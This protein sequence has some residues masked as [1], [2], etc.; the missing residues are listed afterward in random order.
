MFK[1]ILLFIFA[2]LI[3]SSNSYSI[4]VSQIEAERR[5]EFN[6]L[7]SKKTCDT[8]YKNSSFGMKKKLEN[9]VMVVTYHNI[10]R[11]NINETQSILSL[12][13]DQRTFFYQEPK[14]EFII[15]NALSEQD[16]SEE[17]A[18]INKSI[19]QAKTK[20][21]VVCEFDLNKSISEGKYFDF[22]IKFDKALSIQTK[23]LPKILIYY[24]GTVEYVYFDEEIKY[25]IPNFDYRMYPFDDHEFKISITSKIFDKLYFEK[26]DKFKILMNDSKKAN[27]T[28]ISF[29]GWTIKKYI[30][31]ANV[32]NLKDAYSNYT[33]HTIESNFTIKRNWETYAYKFVAPLIGLTLLVYFSVFLRLRDGRANLVTTLLFTFVA[34]D[35]VTIGKTP[36]LPYVTFLDWLI[37]MGYSLCIISCLFSFAES[38]YIRQKKTGGS[39]ELSENSLEEKNRLR[40]E[41]AKYVYKVFIPILYIIITYAGYMTMLI[42]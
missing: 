10:K 30:S 34:Y 37:F 13:L 5:L 41:K 16:F 15:F 22:K 33:K 20:K 6:E 39:A 27:F 28:N 17:M 29:P 35:F 11:I 24:D 32:E 12:F 26:S 1:K 21:I 18:S 2:I 9:D 14:L 8:V 31:Y 7:F 40:F 38:Y 4:E 36:E 23:E 25:S 19:E 3:F 42:S